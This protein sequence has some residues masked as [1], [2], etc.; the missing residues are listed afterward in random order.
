MTVLREGAFGFGAVFGW[1]TACLPSRFLLLGVFRF[2][3]TKS[4]SWNNNGCL[5]SV[6]AQDRA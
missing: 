4:G 3:G 2:A 1:A 5:G 6:Y